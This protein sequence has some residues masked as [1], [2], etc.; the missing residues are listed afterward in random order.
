M[1]KLPPLLLAL[2]ALM[3][4]VI[5]VGSNTPQTAS[6][7]GPGAFYSRCLYDHSAP[8]D[9]IVFFGQPGAAH[10]HDFFGGTPIDAF[11]QPEDLVGGPTTCPDQGDTAG[12]WAPSLYIDGQQIVPH[13]IN[14]RYAAGGKDPATLQPF[15][16]GLKIVA[17]SKVVDGQVEKGSDKYLKWGCKP[18]PNNPNKRFYM[19]CGAN[20]TT[21]NVEFPDCWDGLNLDVPND[22][23]SHM[24]YSK[25]NPATCPEDHPVPLPSLSMKVFYGKNLPEGEATLS[26]GATNTFHTDFLSAWV[27]ERLLEVVN[28]CVINGINCGEQGD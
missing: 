15:P 22:H 11:T 25:G 1:K 14:A 19:H 4:G 16:Q 26:S 3:I 5:G 23:R 20:E 27:P 18:G 9:P 2:G 7:A 12:Y 8:D 28:E 21:A 17:G 6:A 13:R 10:N 24:A